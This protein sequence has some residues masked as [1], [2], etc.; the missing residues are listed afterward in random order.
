MVPAPQVTV[1]QRGDR[2]VAAEERVE[3]GE[4]DFAI[5]LQRAAITVFGRAA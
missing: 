4:Q 3:T 2:R 5:P 1:Q